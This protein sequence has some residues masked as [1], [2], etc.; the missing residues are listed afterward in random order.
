MVSKDIGKCCLIVI[1]GWGVS[2][3]NGAGDAIKAAKTPNM[4]R[5]A[6]DYPHIELTAHG[7]A[8]GLPTGLMGNSEVG[9]LNIG[10]GRPVFQDIVRIEL[11]LEEGNMEKNAVLIEMFNRAK[12]GNGRLHFVGLVSDGGVHAHMDHLKCLLGYA[13]NA[14]VPQVFVHAITDGRDTA[15]TSAAGY[16]ENILSLIKTLDNCK[17]ATV[18]GRYYAMDRDKRWERTKVA[19]DAFVSG[20]GTALDDPVS[21]IK[22]RYARFEPERDEFLKPIITDTDGRIRDGDVVIFFNFRSDRMRQIVS[23][24]GLGRDKLQFEA[25]E[26]PKVSIACMT[27]YNAEFPFPVLSPPQK[28]SNVLAEWLSKQNVAQFHTAET[29]KYAHVT[30]FFNG[31][32]EVTFDGEERRMV[33]SPKVAT[34]DLQPEMSVAQVADSV[35]EALNTAKFPLVMCNFAP[36][37]MVGH[38]GKYLPTIKA[39]E[40]TDEAIGRVYEACKRTGYTLLITSDHGNAEKMISE[41]GGEHTAHTCQPVPFIVT[42]RTIT[43]HRPADRAAALCDVAP[44]ILSLLHLPIPPEMTGADLTRQPMAS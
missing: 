28:L 16:I 12:G 2:P 43:L 27:S 26:Y 44:T 15:P 6:Q 35:I 40:A 30:F 8:V 33:E 24:L 21:E 13:K 4:T 41:D 31:G 5:L 22:A 29:E 20:V 34:Y 9:H 1:D 32:R 25:K 38:T 42:D 17:L 3:A 11:A 10:A 37:D 14:Q 23:S 18:V 7:R 39:V 19:F 36:P